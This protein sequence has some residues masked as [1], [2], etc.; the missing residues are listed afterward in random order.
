MVRFMFVFKQTVRATDYAAMDLGG[1]DSI[2]RPDPV[3]KFR[4]VGA[5]LLMAGYS[6]KASG[7]AWVVLRISRG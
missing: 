5:A 6:G 3:R 1:R 4:I 2:Q 7:S